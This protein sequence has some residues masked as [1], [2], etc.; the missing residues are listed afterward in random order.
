MKNALQQ[1]FFNHRVSDK[2]LLL[3]KSC[4]KLWTDWL[5]NYTKAEILLITV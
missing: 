4:A 3:I 5:N 2:F 1:Y